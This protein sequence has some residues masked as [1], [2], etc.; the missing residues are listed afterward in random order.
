ML[1]NKLIELNIEEYLALVLC[2]L[3]RGGLYSTNTSINRRP[4]SGVT[5][6]N[7][8]NIMPVF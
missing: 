5:K 4:L 1:Q 3:K 2:V 8:V 7:A 6:E